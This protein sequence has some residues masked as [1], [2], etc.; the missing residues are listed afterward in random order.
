MPSSNL[1]DIPEI[2]ELICQ[3]LT[4]SEQAKC[5]RI[6]KS[7]YATI[8]PLIWE[9]VSYDENRS[10]GMNPSPEDLLKFGHIVKDVEIYS[11]LP[12]DYS[13]LQ[14]PNLTILRAWYMLR[15]QHS[16]VS[17]KDG[18]ITLIQLNH[19]LVRLELW[20][21]QISHP[22]IF[23]KA[24]A[25]L[26]NL[27]DLN[28]N[29][30]TVD[31]P[32]W[33]ICPRLTVLT[34]GDTNVL[35]GPQDDLVNSPLLHTLLLCTT[36]SNFTVQEQFKFITQC[37]QLETLSWTPESENIA[38]ILAGFTQNIANG[39]WPR[40]QSLTTHK[41]DVSDKDLAPIL[42]AIRYLTKL[43]VSRTGFGP[44]SFLALRH[45]FS[46]IS[47]LRLHHCEGATSK[48]WAEVL[49]S[50]P[51]LIYIHG[52]NIMAKDI[53]ACPPWSCRSLKT[54]MLSIRFERLVDSSVETA[55]DPLI[56]ATSP[57]ANSTASGNEKDIQRLI[58]KRLSALDQLESLNISDVPTKQRD[59]AALDLRIATGISKEN[60]KDSLFSDNTI[61]VHRRCGVDIAAL[62][63]FEET[64]TLF[65][66]LNFFISE[67]TKLNSLVAA[68][69]AAG[70][71]WT[72][73]SAIKISRSF[74]LIDLDSF[75]GATTVL[76]RRQP[77]T[78]ASTVI[79]F[80]SEPE[81]IVDASVIN[82]LTDAEILRQ[83]K[84]DLDVSTSNKYLSNC[85][86][87]VLVPFT[88]EYESG[89]TS[90][91]F[92]PQD[93]AK[94]A[95][96]ERVIDLRPMKKP[97]T[98]VF[99]EPHDL[100]IALAS[101]RCDELIDINDYKPLEPSFFV[102]DYQEYQKFTINIAQKLAGAVIQTGLQ[103]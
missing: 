42:E 41:D 67:E 25:E 68:F 20:C 56:A 73:L 76:H 12:K 78:L 31:H 100:G 74:F 92:L 87:E 96:S 83:A 10:Q 60:K 101:S 44:N 94:R 37:P 47:D 52:S 9:R 82:D 49:S 23:W 13:T 59:H 85:I 1:F 75:G 2:R 57:K 50:C 95:V 19:S 58:F 3:Q 45:H 99:T 35:I 97:K 6:S 22:P 89:S 46:T 66:N 102:Q 34:L 86:M 53:I 48:V 17:G 5:M 62:D 65:T 93:A 72:S 71:P 21:V 98:Q 80:D 40:L 8:L 63:T 18:F 32:F 27:R 29:R 43:S 26:P 81:E 7:W 69:I 64:S 84:I 30:V 33:T 90:S 16:S 28:C 77:I 24:V 15:D 39:T 103:G 38:P 61:N 11:A 54:W 36:T 4:R 51:S 70:A 55:I 79:D 91:A 14:F 88:V